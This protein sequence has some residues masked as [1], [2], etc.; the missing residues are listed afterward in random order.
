M[1]TVRVIRMILDP[2]HQYI[3]LCGAEIGHCSPLLNVLYD[4][5]FF[6]QLVGTLACDVFIGDAAKELLG[7]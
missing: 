1:G 7:D 4:V 2:P 6:Q 3:L 5:V